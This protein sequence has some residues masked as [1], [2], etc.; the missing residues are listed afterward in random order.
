MVYVLLSL[1]HFAPQA[2]QMRLLQ[3]PKTPRIHKPYFL[4][5]SSKLYFIPLF[6]LSWNMVVFFGLFLI[7]WQ[8]A[9]LAY[10]SPFCHL[11]N[12]YF[13]FTS[14]PIFYDLGLSSLADRRHFID[15][16]FLSNLLW[17]KLILLP[18]C[19]N[20]LSNLYLSYTLFFNF[21]YFSLHYKLLSE[22][23]YMPSYAHY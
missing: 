16:L 22:L 3:I 14:L 4:T 13:P 18:Y 21:T 2:Y 19:L 17:T 15:I 11:Q 1:L 7:R 10:I 5:Q 20:L 8:H 9:N 23:P 12:Q 6:V